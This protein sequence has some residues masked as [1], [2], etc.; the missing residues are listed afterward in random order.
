MALRSKIYTYFNKPGFFLGKFERFSVPQI[1]FT[2]LLL[3]LFQTKIPI[4]F[5]TQNFQISRWTNKL[6]LNILLI[7]IN[8]KL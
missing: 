8:Y 7:I 2:Y 6:N 4:D 1:F 5:Y 3:Y